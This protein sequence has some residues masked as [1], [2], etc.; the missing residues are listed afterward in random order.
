MRN[1]DGDFDD[2]FDV[3]VN[4]KSGDEIPPKSRLKYWEQ[5]KDLCISLEQIGEAVRATKTAYAVKRGLDLSEHEAFF[6]SPKFKIQMIAAGF[7]HVVNE[8][9]PGKYVYM[10]DLK[11]ALGL[12]RPN[13]SSYFVA[14]AKKRLLS[15]GKLLFNKFGVGHKLATPEEAVEEFLKTNGRAAGHLVNMCKRLHA[16]GFTR[17]M[18]LGLSVEQRE[19][20]RLS[21]SLGVISQE[22]LS[23]RSGELG[24]LSQEARSAMSELQALTTMPVFG[25]D[26]SDLANKI[27]TT[28]GAN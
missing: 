20:L 28:L 15:H 8:R 6:A 18:I 14:T 13:Q 21:V 4:N 5:R 9:Y 1:G 26:V 7:Y 24:D 22:F 10:F 23:A 27:E 12:D 16:V 17:E 11:E 3:D 2:H 19:L 25:D